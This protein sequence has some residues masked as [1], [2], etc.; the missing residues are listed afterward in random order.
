MRSMAQARF[1][2]VGR[3][4]RSNSA[5]SFTSS[6]RIAANA[7]PNAA[8]QPMAGAPRTTMSRI[9]ASTSRGLRQA[10]QITSRGSRR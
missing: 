5:A 8:A 1:T 10:I 3:A 6:P 2:A 4:R 7:R 9:A